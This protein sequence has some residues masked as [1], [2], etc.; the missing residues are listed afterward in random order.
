MNQQEALRILIQHTVL[1]TGVIKEK[2]LASMASLSEE[3]VT[4]LGRLLATEKERAL[5]GIKEKMARASDL[6]AKIDGVLNTK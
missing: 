4:Q 5:A 3:D 2:I 1:F 6:I